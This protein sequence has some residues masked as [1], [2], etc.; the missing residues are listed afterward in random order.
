MKSQQAARIFVL[1]AVLFAAVGQVRAS[2]LTFDDVPGG[3]LQSSTGDMPPYQG[4]IF[5]TQLDWV[6]LKGPI[7]YARN[8]GAHSGEFA[9]HNSSWSGLMVIED[10]NGD[11][12]TFD[13]LWAKKWN[14]PKQSGGTDALFGTLSGLNNGNKIWSVS[15]GLNGSYEY[16]GA[17][18]G[19]IDTLVLG[20]A[21]WPGGQFLVDDITLNASPVPEP[22]PLVLWTGLGI[23]G[24]FAV[25]RRRK[26]AVSFGAHRVS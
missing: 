10:Q 16:Y 19:L 9:I 20:F 15:T 26:Q 24:L 23:M 1:M 17:Q 22:S 13:G 12:F 11:D 5:S 7:N 6:D 18:A 14:T 2:I 4:F 25:R 21:G 3:S 8:F